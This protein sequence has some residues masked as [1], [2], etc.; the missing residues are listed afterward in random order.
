MVERDVRVSVPVNIIVK[1]T[2][3]HKKYI[4]TQMISPLNF[5]STGIN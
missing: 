4:I 5:K 2:I 1:K 3:Y